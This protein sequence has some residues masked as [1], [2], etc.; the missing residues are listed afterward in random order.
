MCGWV[1][2]SCC[3]EGEVATRRQGL[4]CDDDDDAQT[5]LRRKLSLLQKPDQGGPGELENMC[6]YASQKRHEII[7]VL[8]GR[9]GGTTTAVTGDCQRRESITGIAFLSLS[10]LQKRRKGL[11]S[12]P[13]LRIPGPPGQFNERKQQQPQMLLTVEEV[14]ELLLPIGSHGHQRSIIFSS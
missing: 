7:W 5:S 2:S 3:C 8:L 10:M 14:G 4:L 9:G 12:L 13:F 6:Y 11:S 1:Y